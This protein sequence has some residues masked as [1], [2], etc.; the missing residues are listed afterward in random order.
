[1]APVFPLLR[2][3]HETQV[4]GVYRQVSVNLSFETVNHL[5]T[6]EDTMD[7]ERFEYRYEF[8]NGDVMMFSISNEN[9]LS[10]GDIRK[11]VPLLRGMDRS[12]RNNNQKERRRHCSLD[13]YNL[14]GELF[15]AKDG[16]DGYREDELW[17]ELSHNLTMREKLIGE[18]YF[19]N[20]CKAAEIGELLGITE[21]YAQHLIRRIRR[22]ILKKHK[23]VRF[24]PLP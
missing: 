23:A 19:R 5:K 1:M 17:K 15:H 22:K 11:W 2:R 10:K 20:G 16:F 7:K 13:A 3:S 18:L 9:G 14:N 12:E 24:W 8:A 21:R 6:L 4:G